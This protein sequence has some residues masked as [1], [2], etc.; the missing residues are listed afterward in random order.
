MIRRFTIKQGEYWMVRSSNVIVR[1]GNKLL[2]VLFISYGDK[3][4]KLNF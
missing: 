3:I 1:H 4:I 2:A